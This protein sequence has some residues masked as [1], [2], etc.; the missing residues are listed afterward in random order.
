MCLR[1]VPAVK[2][3]SL[4]SPLWS[5]LAGVGQLDAR[6]FS[7]GPALARALL[8]SG[9][10]LRGPLASDPT[11]VGHDENA[12]ALMRRACFARAE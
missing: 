11:A 12:E 2:W 10:K 8:P 7:V 3:S 5:R 9:E 6:S 4:F 1:P